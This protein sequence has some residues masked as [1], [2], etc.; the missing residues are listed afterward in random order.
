LGSRCSKAFFSEIVLIF[1]FLQVV[2]LLPGKN[3]V[4]ESRKSVFLNSILQSSVHQPAPIA[5]V[6]QT[7]LFYRKTPIIN[8]VLHNEF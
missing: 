3:N 5:N 8:F 6:D 2:S 4:I 1:G 7:P